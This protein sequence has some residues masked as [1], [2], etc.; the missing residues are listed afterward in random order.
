MAATSSF[1]LSFERSVA[2]VLAMKLSACD[3]RRVEGDR[4]VKIAGIALK[5]D[6]GTGE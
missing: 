4:Q 2:Q 3:I 5:I 1:E 6:E